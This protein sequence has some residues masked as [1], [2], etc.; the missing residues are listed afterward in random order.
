MNVILFGYRG[1]GKTTLGQKLADKLWKGFIDTDARVRERFGGLEVADIWAQYGEPA[2]R[3]AEVEAT[4]QALGSEN[5]VIAL[6]GGTMMQPGAREAV[7]A[8][9]DAK[10][11][12]LSCDPAVLLERLNADTATAG[13]RPALTGAGSASDAGLAEIRH[14]LAERD[15]VYRSAAD[16]VLDVTYCTIDDAVTHLV[17]L[18]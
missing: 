4:I 2:F 7:A 12:Y 5:Q 3:T 13:Q 17:A 11:V 16:A 8:A 14:V 1:C 15:P 18:V 6:G 10:R 9:E